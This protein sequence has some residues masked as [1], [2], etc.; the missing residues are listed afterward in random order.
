MAMQILANALP[1]FRDLRGPIIAGYLWLVCAWLIVDPNLDKRPGS[2]PGK[3]LYDMAHHVGRLGVF[4]ALSVAAYFI[5]SAS[6]FLS[7]ALGRLWRQSR[8]RVTA[9]RGR[10]NSGIRELGGGS[11][12]A[13][14]IYSAR[15]NVLSTLKR[16]SYDTE[17]DPPPW[18]RQQKANEMI[19]FVEGRAYIAVSE[20]ELE[21]SVPA[22]LL[23]GK[24]PELFAEVD[25]LSAE[26][27]LRLSVIPPLLALTVVASLQGSPWWLVAVIPTLLLLYQGIAKDEDAQ[28]TVAQAVERGL[29][30]SA[31]LTRFRDWIEEYEHEVDAEI[32]KPAEVE[33]AT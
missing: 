3:A 11:P 20:I 1:G 6:Q 27:E 24:E 4:L 15:S 23:V 9:F 18:R 5:G 17:N 32:Q 13:V 30:Q 7:Q 8:D 22:I 28:R 14:L 33:R 26:G 25:R 10:K 31:V 19:G 21:L 16:W 12:A 2:E 29:I